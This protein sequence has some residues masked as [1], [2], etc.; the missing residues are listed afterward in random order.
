M[1]Q[2]IGDSSY[3][4]CGRA[5]SRCPFRQTANE[6][7][8]LRLYEQWRE[9]HWGP[10][11]PEWYLCDACA[12]ELDPPTSHI[13]APIGPMDMCYVRRCAIQNG[14]PTCAHC[15][16]FPCEHLE[17]IARG[18]DRRVA[19]RR[20]GRR[21]TQE[22]Y[23]RFYEP[24]EGL[25]HLR[26][27][28]AGLRPAEIV[29]VQPPPPR[30]EAEEFPSPTKLRGPKAVLWRGLHG[31]LVSLFSDDAATFAEQDKAR[32]RR[33]VLYNVLWV[34]AR[35]GRPP[36]GDRDYISMDGPT[37]MGERRRR[38]LN[39]WRQYFGLCTDCTHCGQCAFVRSHGITMRGFTPDG[40]PCAKFDTRTPFELRLRLSEAAGGVSA[41]RALMDYTAA[42]AALYGRGAPR[43]FARADM[44]LAAADDAEGSYRSEAEQNKESG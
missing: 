6:E 14:V 4:K 21:L 8:R 34:F 43:H 39:R 18:P 5:C 29:Q 3:G 24:F 9:H 28:R 15:S 23:L 37:F 40:R 12:E 38:N 33:R 36:R 22:E 32:H 7:E 26:R 30:A 10:R 44:S 13:H 19:E 16:L 2:R 41:L 25:K 35:R 42:L 31:L 27:I 11:S 17:P 1:A 20:L